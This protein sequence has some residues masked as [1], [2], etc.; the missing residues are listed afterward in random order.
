MLILF[1]ARLYCSRCILES[2]ST[3]KQGSLTIN[4]FRW[5]LFDTGQVYVCV[6]VWFNARKCCIFKKQPPLLR[7]RSVRLW[8]CDVGTSMVCKRYA[9]NGWQE[10]NR[11][12]SLHTDVG[13][14]LPVA[15]THC[16]MFGTANKQ[17]VMQR[18][19][20]RAIYCALYFMHI[21]GKV[22]RNILHC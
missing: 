15:H 22:T 17:C 2:A 7:T 18:A 16:C 12:H 20:Y 14:M 1:F 4:K 13:E 6:C 11:V 9:V 21:I 8:Y 3:Y 19:R 10:A 5:I